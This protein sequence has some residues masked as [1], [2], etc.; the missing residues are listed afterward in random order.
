MER[1]FNDPIDTVYDYEENY[2][3]YGISKEITTRNDFNQDL[4]A[5][6]MAQMVQKIPLAITGGKI[7]LDIYM[8]FITILVPLEKKIGGHLM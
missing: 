3:S 6:Q 7:H 8:V 5:P 1:I 2:K 4:M